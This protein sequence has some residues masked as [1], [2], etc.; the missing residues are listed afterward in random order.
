MYNARTPLFWRYCR[1]GAHSLVRRGLI[2]YVSFWLSYSKTSQ[3]PTNWDQKIP[4]G[5]FTCP[6]WNILRIFLRVQQCQRRFRNLHNKAHFLFYTTS[7]G[8]SSYLQ[9]SMEVPLQLFMHP[10]GATIVKY[11]HNK[12]GVSSHMQPLLPLTT[13][14][15]TH[16]SQALWKRQHN[17][18]GDHNTHISTYAWTQKKESWLASGD[19]RCC[20]PIHL[21]FASLIT[22]DNFTQGGG[23]S[24]YRNA[25]RNV[26]HARIFQVVGGKDDGI[27]NPQGF[28]AGGGHEPA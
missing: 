19:S 11:M 18:R 4:G 15:E 27:R 25:D 20:P 28:A 2:T 10:S 24:R 14:Q 17:L 12:A 1:R 9:Y 16:Q 3:P 8:G 13:I 7:V 21:S 6:K 22:H 23:R 26:D 5:R